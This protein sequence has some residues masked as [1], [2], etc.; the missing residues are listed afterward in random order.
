MSR[1]LEPVFRSTS[2]VDRLV[3]AALDV[4]RH[5]KGPKKKK[6]SPSMFPICPI[7][8]FTYLFHQETRG[9][10]ESKA[11]ALLN[12]FADAGK[13]QHKHIQDALGH[14]GMMHGNWVCVNPECECA[15]AAKSVYDASGKRTKKG[16]ATRTRSENNICP[17]CGSIMDYKELLILYKGLKGYVDAVIKNP[18]GTYS[19]VDLK[20]TTV[21]KATNDRAFVAYQRLQ[22]AA[23][24]YVLKRRYGYDIVDY[25]LVY[26]PRDNPKKFVSVKFPFNAKEAKKAKRLIDGEVAKWSAA[27]KAVTTGDVFKIESLKPCKTED[28]Y[29]SEVHT[30]TQCPFTGCCFSSAQL[31]SKLKQFMQL[32]K[33]SPHLSLDGVLSEVLSSKSKRQTG[34]GFVK[35]QNK[36][37]A[38]KNVS[39]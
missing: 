16:K 22:I 20:S 8:W 2:Q 23:Y 18:D 3:D 4:E 33:A 39:I 13:A 26:V 9:Y 36:R 11:T 37:I 6:L 1:N 15:K 10:T 28:Q 5:S 38:V 35:G 7:K 24:A 29:W 14:S 12:I 32:S 30:Y 31:H 27:K 34:L 19:L 25:T 17:K 21:D